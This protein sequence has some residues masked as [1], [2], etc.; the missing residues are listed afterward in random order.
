MKKDG[1]SIVDDNGEEVKR[2]TSVKEMM[3]EFE[4][5]RKNRKWLS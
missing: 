3:D 2:Y 1:I 4:T 5:K